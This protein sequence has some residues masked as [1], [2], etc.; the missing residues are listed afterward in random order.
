MVGRRFCS[1]LAGTALVVA[2]SAPASIAGGQALPSPAP[3]TRADENSAILKP[4]AE[5]GRVRARTPYCGALA[6]ARAGIDSAITFQYSTPILA[7]DLRGFRLD[8]YLTKERSLKKTERDLTG[9]WN[10]AVAGR[11]DVR[12]L[13]AAANADGVDAEKRKEMLAFADALDGAKARQMQLAK[14]MA[15]TYAVLAE[16]PIRDIANTAA[17]DHGA[18]A[19]AP[20]SAML[21]PQAPDDASGAPVR[22]TT[23][24]DAIADHTQSQDL[25]TAF[26]AERFIRD[27]LKDAALHGNKAVQLGGCS[28]I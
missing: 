4:L 7:N 11:D 2:L 10:L 6:R 13:R 20:K 22:T 28:G 9:L 18:T 26:G 19:I 25:F 1:G 12:A 5:I 14:S 15:R 24:A 27:D 23:T 8:S 21:R 17:D 3:A 16:M